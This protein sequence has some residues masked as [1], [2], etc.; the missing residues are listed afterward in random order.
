MRCLWDA[1]EDEAQLSWE[2]QTTLTRVRDKVTLL[3]RKAIEETLN[4]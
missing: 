1:L 3:T 2:W 4:R